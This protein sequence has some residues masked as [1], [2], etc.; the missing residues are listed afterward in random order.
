MRIV[1][2][3]DEVLLREGL[4]S[5]LDAAGVDVVGLAWDVPSLLKAVS[6]QLSRPQS[7][8]LRRHRPV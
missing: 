8:D 6:L 4:A 3:D 2:C 1:I 7:T 5:L